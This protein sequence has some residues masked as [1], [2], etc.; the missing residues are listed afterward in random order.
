MSIIYNPKTRL[1]ETDFVKVDG[2]YLEL[3][4]SDDIPN[5]VKYEIKTQEITSG[6]WFKLKGRQFVPPEEDELTRHV[7]IPKYYSKSDVSVSSLLRQI[8]EFL[9]SCLDLDARHRF[10]LVCFVL[11]TWLV[12]RLPIAPIL[13]IVGPPQSGK[14]T[15]LNALY[16]LCRRGLLTSDISSAAFNRTCDRLIP[17]VLIDNTATAGQE[18]KL[19]H[20]LRSGNT[21]SIVDSSGSQS[22]GTY[23]AK[24]VSWTELPDDDALNSRCIIISMQQNSRMDLLRTTDSRIVSLAYELQGQL[25]TYRWQ[26]YGT[27]QLPQTPG[28]KSLRSRDRDLYEALALPIADDREACERLMECM[29]KQHD[30]HT[31]SLPPKHAA[32]L[33]TLFHQIH[34]HTEQG[35]LTI[36]RLTEEVNLNLERAGEHFRLTSK[37]VG[38]ALTSLGLFFA[39]TRTSSGWEGCLDR[40]ARKLVHDLVSRHGMDGFA[41]YLPSEKPSEPCEFCKARES[42]SLETAPIEESTTELPI[43]SAEHKPGDVLQASVQAEKDPAH[44]LVQPDLGGAQSS[45]ETEKDRIE[46]LVRK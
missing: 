3:S 43:E 26:K 14:T 29:E 40:A 2:C 31:Q 38:T 23:G 19:I 28:A 12:D 15:V 9:S 18:R 44:P 16:L 45:D 39:R 13:S 30:L 11:S 32:V 17:T 1:F 5:L 4:Q 22:Y 24:V 7:R 10:L 21:P 8:D 6:R 25:Q 34:L 37:A 41:D 35:T 27:L 46:S 42:Q 36:G 20:L 33:G